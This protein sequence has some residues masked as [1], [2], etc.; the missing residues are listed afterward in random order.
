MTGKIKQNL[1]SESGAVAIVEATF[2]F[3]VMFIVLFFLIYM[4]NA[5]YIKAQVE[6]VVERYAIQG[7]AYCA[8]PI[9]ETIKETGSVPSLSSPDLK[10]EPY[11]YIFGGMD[12][13]ETDICNFV[14]AEIK[15]SSVTFFRN[16]E[17]RLIT[18]THNIAKF[19]NYVV[20]STF[21]VEA[22]YEIQFPIKFFG[23][24]TPAVL[25]IS[26]RA[27]VPVNDTAEFIRNTDMVIDVFHG[28]KIGQKISDVFGKINDFIS[29]FASK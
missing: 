26:S 23:S 3:P 18:P 16:M 25:T 15:N 28:T 13:V 9:L 17:P 2:V 6:S 29:S 10:I 20:Y 5:Y 22:K 11:R 4:G 27:E 12:N 14:E 8:D 7:A 1:T 24:N 21:S 19:N